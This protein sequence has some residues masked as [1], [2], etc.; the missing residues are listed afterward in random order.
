MEV[1]PEILT[2]LEVTCPICL[3][4]KPDKT[5]RV[6]TT[7]VSKLAPGFM[8]WM[9]FSFFNVESIYGFTSDFVASCSANSYPFG[10]TP[11]RKFPP[12]YIL[13]FLV[14]TLMNQDNK[15]ALI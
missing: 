11:S 3:L 10:F 8:L 13:K 6:P 2:Y 7:D 1:I 14:T 15:A 9:G 5:P 4:T 12:F